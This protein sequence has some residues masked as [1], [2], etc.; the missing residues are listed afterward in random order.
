MLSKGKEA[1]CITVILFILVSSKKSAQSQ[2]KA[3]FSTSLSQYR[4]YFGTELYLL[5]V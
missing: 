1:T 2:H 3:Q 4:T 5:N